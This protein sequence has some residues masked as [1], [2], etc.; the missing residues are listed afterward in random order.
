MLVRARETVRRPQKCRSDRLSNGQFHLPRNCER[1]MR[2]RRCTILPTLRPIYGIRL[3]RC[4]RASCA[5]LDTRKPVNP[6]GINL[7]WWLDLGRFAGSPI[8]TVVARSAEF[9]E[10]GI[11]GRISACNGA[12]RRKD[13]ANVNEHLI[14]WELISMLVRTAILEGI[15]KSF[16]AAFF[17]D[18]FQLAA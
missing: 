16:T 6:I 12:E 9:V 1:S 15:Q 2:R 10:S 11:S 7:S 3:N 18:M 17:T 14:L 5:R 8:G 13:S 4:S